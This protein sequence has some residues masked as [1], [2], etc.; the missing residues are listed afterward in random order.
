[1]ISPKT[2]EAIQEELTGHLRSRVEW[3]EAPAVFTVH[4][5]DDGS[6]LLARLPVPE[7]MWSDCGHPPTAVAG[8]AA[9][10]TGLPRYPDGSH[11]LVRPGVG[12]LIGAAIRYEAY[13]LS[14]DSQSPAVREAVR[15]RGAGGSVPRFEDIPGRI[16]Q[17]CMTAVDLDGGR[18]MASSSRIDELELEATEPTVHYLAF[19][20]PRRD[21]LT[22]NVVDAAIRFL[23]AIKPVP[24]KGAA[25]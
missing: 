7:S 9:V 24:T 1:M 21:S 13:A 25:R 23:N 10:A 4:Q 22:G 8:L 16:E 12:K 19:G 17:R 2:A 14:E 6:V 18:Y 3:D 20:D 11:L 15:R 5:S